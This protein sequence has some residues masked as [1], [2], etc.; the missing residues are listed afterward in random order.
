[1][2]AAARSQPG[3]ADLK[4]DADPDKSVC[5]LTLNDRQVKVIFWNDPLQ[6]VELETVQGQGV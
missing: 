5:T 1:V 4:V 3:T 2:R 6:T